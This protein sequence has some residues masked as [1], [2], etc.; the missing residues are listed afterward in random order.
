MATVVSGGVRASCCARVMS[1]PTRRVRRA[2]R[3]AAPASL[4]WGRP[5]VSGWAGRRRAAG[6]FSQH[7]GLAACDSDLNMRRTWRPA[8]PGPRRSYF[9]RHQRCLTQILSAD[10]RRD[11]TGKGGNSSPPANLQLFFTPRLSPAVD[12]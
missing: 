5:S 6:V 1:S 12:T 8:P 3:C 10:K 4:P 7:G 2:P 11:T 9:K